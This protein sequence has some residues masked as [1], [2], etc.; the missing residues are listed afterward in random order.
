MSFL[1]ILVG[2]LQ[3]LMKSANLGN[4]GVLR[5]GVGIPLNS[6]SPRQ[7]VACPRRGATKREAWTLLRLGKGLRRSVA[8]FTDMCFCH[9]L[10]FCYSEN[11]SIELMRTL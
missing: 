2:F 11:L 6:V 4:F 7:G 3:K 1:L 8:L 10:L 9:V 5:R